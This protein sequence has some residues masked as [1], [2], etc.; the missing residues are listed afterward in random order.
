MDDQKIKELETKAREIRI[1]V[2]EMIYHAGSGHLGSSFSTVEL[3]TALY[4]GQLLRFNPQ[5]PD[6]AE[7]DFFLL[8]NG[9]ACPALYALL[10][11]NGFFPQ[12]K[13]K[14]LRQLDS[15]LE[16]HPRRGS[17]PGIEIS[18]GS[19][20]MGLAQGLGIALGLQLAKKPNQV[21]VLMSDG[22]QDEG[23]T[24]EA[25]MAAG[26]F[27][28]ANLTAVIDRNRVQIGGFTEK[29]M[30]LEPLGAKYESFNW[31]VIEIDG[32]DFSQIFRAFRQ[33][34]ARRGPSLII[35][36]TKACQGLPFLEGRPDVHHPQVDRDLY[37]KALE[38]LK[39]G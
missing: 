11:D 36:Q 14:N 15:G 5:R 3:L 31:R 32:H 25:V 4:S 37:H 1:K 26:H 27:Q 19:L 10:A 12:K 23:A 30:A 16:G 8:S 2:L 17:L 9:H 33:A 6:W 22:E 39:N 13:L 20:G 28:P 21:V 29:Q 24:W 18:S 35:S 34:F 38:E 7:R